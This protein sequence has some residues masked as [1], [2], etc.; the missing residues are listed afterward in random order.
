MIE[1]ND[2]KISEQKKRKNRINRQSCRNR[3]RSPRKPEKNNPNGATKCLS[4]ETAEEEK[5]NRRKEYLKWRLSKK[6]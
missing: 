1:P 6:K 2:D 4:G 5:E 3:T